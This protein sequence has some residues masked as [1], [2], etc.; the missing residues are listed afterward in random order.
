MIW[1]LGCPLPSTSPV[2]FVLQVELPYLAAQVLIFCPVAYFMVNF[3]V[4]G[5]RLLRMPRTRVRR[6]RT[7]KPWRPAL[8]ARTKSPGAGGGWELFLLHARL[9]PQVPLAVVVLLPSAAE[10]LGGGHLYLTTVC[11][12]CSLLFYTSLGQA[13]LYV[14]PNVQAAQAVSATIL[15][16]ADIFNGF[17]V[18]RNQVCHR[19]WAAM[20]T[21]HMCSTWGMPGASPAA[22]V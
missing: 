10:P 19:R 2:V 7:S 14:M 1:N 12:D 18:A 6:L 8:M 15:G 16:L 5:L 3:T 22:P 20:P 4:R 13:V 21:A 17:F 11:V 9:L